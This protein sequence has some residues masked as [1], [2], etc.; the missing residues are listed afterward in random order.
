MKKILIFKIGA[1][2]DVLM[3]TP[4]VKQLGETNK[5]NIDY[6]CGNQV[7]QILVGN[8]FIDNIINFDEKFFAK[9]NIGN[10]FKFIKFL[11]FLFSISKKYDYLIILDKH[12]IF[13][14][15]FF[16]SGFKNRF[17]FNRLGKE[18]K[19]LNKYIFWD[20]SKREVEY[21]LDFLNF[22]DIK[23]DYK[24]QKYD[25]FG[26]IIDKLNNGEKLSEKENNLVKK[27]IP[28]K[29]EIDNFIGD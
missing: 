29:E 15:M 2:G 28:K 9:I 4:F 16:I 21:Y 13:N 8:K 5:Y 18:G 25:F 10:L 12:I 14:F 17:G 11:F 1:L 7:S 19:F 26:G 20:K 23:P 3:T 22:F 27:Y 6:M 24:R